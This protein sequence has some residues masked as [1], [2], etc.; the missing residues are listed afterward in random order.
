MTAK[1]LM[2]FL[3][4]STQQPVIRIGTHNTDDYYPNFVAEFFPEN[5]KVNAA[6][7][8]RGVS[9]RGRKLHL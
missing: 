7:A 4:T 1:I 8:R 5:M 9:L 6:T 3:N 2:E